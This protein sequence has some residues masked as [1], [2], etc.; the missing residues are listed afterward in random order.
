MRTI[1]VAAW[2]GDIRNVPPRGSRCCP[3][4]VPF[5]KIARFGSL[6]ALAALL[7]S[8]SCAKTP[9]VTAADKEAAETREALS[10]LPEEDRKL[11]EEQ[12]TCPVGHSALGSMGTPIKV[13]VGGKPVFICCEG[14]RKSLLADYEKSKAAAEGAAGEAPAAEKPAGT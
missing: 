11:A 5:M 10:K 1:V 8:S 13:D 7:V 3:G 9:P 2:D 4:M 12:K 6:F 14:C